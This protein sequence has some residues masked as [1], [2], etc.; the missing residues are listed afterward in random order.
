ML[1][2]INQPQF[3]NLQAGSEGTLDI[4]TGHSY[5][6][7]QVFLEVNTGSGFAPATAQFM[8]DNIQEIDFEISVNGIGNIK[9]IDGLTGAQ[10]LDM[11]NYRKVVREVGML[12]IQFSRPESR[13]STGED[14]SVLGTAD[15]TS[16][17]LKLKLASGSYEVRAKTIG[18]ADSMTRN[19]GYDAEG[20]LV[21]GI[22]AYDTVSHAQYGAGKTTISNIPKG[23]TQGI[24]SA[25]HI[26]NNNT[27]E[28]LELKQNNRLIY[29]AEN[30]AF[31]KQYVKRRGTRTPVS[32]I[33]SIDFL[34]GL[35]RMKS[36][37]NLNLTKSLFL[38][39]VF[40]GSSTVTMIRERFISRGER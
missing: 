29:K 28:S 25:L 6:E 10:Y 8:R 34:G 37:I 36:G 1:L 21:A 18:L 19:F 14:L 32:G 4:H 15:A 17:V 39:A 38:D 13:T 31:M 24:M 20:K 2:N 22:Y 3:I 40:T 7:I 5:H 23:E 12:P 27:L 26:V 16:V 11:L 30:E 35:N 33:W 9:A